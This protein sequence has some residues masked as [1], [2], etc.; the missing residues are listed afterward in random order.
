M[1]NTPYST[2]DLGLASFLFAKDVPLVSIQ[3]TTDSRRYFF[4]FQL[5]EDIQPLIQGFWNSTELIQ[6]IKLLNAE[7][8]LKRRLYSDSYNI[9]QREVDH[10]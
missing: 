8:E 10:V 9:S 3:P 2:T 5:A 7:K 4:V 6:P 1:K